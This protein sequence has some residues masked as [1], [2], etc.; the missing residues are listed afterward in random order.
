M[1]Q[2]L[3]VYM[4]S[5][6]TTPIVR[7]MDRKFSINIG[8]E[9]SKEDWLE[10]LAVPDAE[11]ELKVK[12]EDVRHLFWDEDDVGHTLSIKVVPVE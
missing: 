12:V 4:E 5:Y 7:E 1:S 11:L 8:D 6:K 10:L 9:I 2:R 3:E